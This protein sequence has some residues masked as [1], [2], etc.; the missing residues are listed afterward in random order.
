MA[1]GKH[2]YTPRF[3]QNILLY[4]IK[5][6]GSVVTQHKAQTRTKYQCWRL[7]RRHARAHSNQDARAQNKMAQDDT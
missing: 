4:R 7:I 6:T 5:D 1:P 2:A 3:F